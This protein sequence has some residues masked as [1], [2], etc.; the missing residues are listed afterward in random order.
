MMSDICGRDIVDRL[1]VLITG[2][3][4]NQLL[5]VPKIASG[6]GENM[7]TA[8][9]NAIQDWNVSENIKPLCFNTTSS[10]TGLKEGACT[11]IEQKLE[12]SL[13]YL[14]CRHHILEIL[15]KCMFSNYFG[16]SSGNTA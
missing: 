13:L 11:S 14:A 6:T 15:L 10:N 8:V 9:Y 7:A 12:H 1:P 4:I 3:G 2:H 16:S 5:C